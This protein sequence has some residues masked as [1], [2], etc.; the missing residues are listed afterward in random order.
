MIFVE[1]SSHLKTERS[2]TDSTTE[3]WQRLKVDRVSTFCRRQRPIEVSDSKSK[4]KSLQELKKELLCTSRTSVFLEYLRTFKPP[5]KETLRRAKDS[6]NGDLCTFA[7][8][9][10]CAS[11]WL[12]AWWNM[13]CP[14]NS[15]PLLWSPL[16]IYSMMTG[17]KSDRA[18]FHRAG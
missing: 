3:S 11:S 7:S 16:T 4:I 17:S 5:K 15:R 12:L 2:P 1:I 14:T 18:S 8:L 13:C 6:K 9:W 10:L